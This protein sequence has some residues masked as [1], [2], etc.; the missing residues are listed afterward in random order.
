MAKRD[1][2]NQLRAEANLRQ[3]INESLNGYTDALKKIGRLKRT[4]SELDNLITEKISD[5]LNFRMINILFNY[6]T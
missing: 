2:I 5:G 1:I 4:I 3:E 6:V